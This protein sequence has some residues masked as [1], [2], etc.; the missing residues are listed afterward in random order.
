MKRSTEKV[1]CNATDPYKAY[2]WISEVEHNRDLSLRVVDQA[3]RRVFLGENVPPSDKIVS[4]IE[5]HTD[6]IVKGQ[7]DVQYEH[8][9]NLA[10]QAN[11]FVAYLN[12]ESRNPSDNSLYLPVLDACTTDYGRVPIETVADGGYASQNNVSKGCS[13]GV[14]RV[15]F[16]K[17]CGLGFHDMGYSQCV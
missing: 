10:T 9:I 2:K 17:R 15:V 7:R 5:P 13:D 12:I 4:L 8:K 16:H 14:D 3:Q 1:S 6:I 11:G